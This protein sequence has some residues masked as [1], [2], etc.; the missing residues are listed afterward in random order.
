MS[1]DNVAFLVRTYSPDKWGPQKSPEKVVVGGS[2]V[3]NAIYIQS[4]R[5]MKISSG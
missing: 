5:A 2:G 4:A 1:G 3:E